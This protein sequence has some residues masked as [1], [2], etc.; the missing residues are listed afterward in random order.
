MELSNT[1]QIELEDLD[2]SSI[3]TL[4]LIIDE[5]LGHSFD[6]RIFSVKAKQKFVLYLSDSSE[7]IRCAKEKFIEHNFR[8]CNLPD[9]SYDSFII[10]IQNICNERTSNKIKLLID[11]TLASSIWYGYILRFFANCELPMDTIEIYFSNSLIQSN[12]PLKSSKSKFTFNPLFINSNTNIEKRPLAIIV[13]QS[14]FNKEF[15]KLFENQFN[16]KYV[17][18]FV[19]KRIADRITLNE[20]I[21]RE[22]K[23]NVEIHNFLENKVEETDTALRQLVIR[24]RLN[25]KVSIL[26]THSKTFSLIASL[27]NARYPDVDIW[28]Q[29]PEPVKISY[30]KTNS[31]IYKAVMI[32]DELEY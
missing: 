23:C 29:E 28:Q 19:E 24:L 20:Q 5:H 15:I 8:L 2:K 27:I 18:W 13:E 21:S 3:D 9:N 1:S 11:N 25:Y 22:L 32:N 12:V 14:F 17:I 4:L 31:L 7:C 6:E 16:P 10:E 30:E 26:T